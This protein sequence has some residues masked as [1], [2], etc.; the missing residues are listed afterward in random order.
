MAEAMERARRQWQNQRKTEATAGTSPVR[1]RVRFTVA[2]SRE[3]GTNGS[4]IAKA[5]GERL[6][7]VVYDRELVQH[8][9]AD[10]GVRTSLVESVDEKHRNWLLS[11]LESF[12]SG[13]TVSNNTYA[14]QLLETLLSLGAHGECIIVGR[15]AAQVLPADATLGVRLVGPLPD[16]IKVVSQRSGIPLLEAK[17]WVEK[18]D[19]ERVRF[20]KD[21]FQKDS[22]DPRGYDLV[23]N[24]SRFSVS[25]CADIIIEALRRLQARAGEETVTGQSA[26]PTHPQRQNALS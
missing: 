13:L 14:V 23:L 2:L 6:G 19:A 17:Q 11:C 26:T 1:A 5:I 3:A 8:I 20:T 9:A 12:G 10:M 25:E 7:W 22:T 18:T 4:L 24:S 21:H 16:R 15:G